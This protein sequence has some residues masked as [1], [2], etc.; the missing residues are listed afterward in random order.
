MTI[1]IHL[2]P[3]PARYFPLEKGIYEVAPGLSPLGA[4]FGNGAADEK[5]FQIDVEFERY[6]QN[7]ISCRLERLEK[8]FLTRDFDLG[9]ERAVS[10]FL[11]AR[12][13]VEYPDFFKYKD[14]TLDCLLTGD[15]LEFND[16]FDLVGERTESPN[17]PPFQSA[18]DALCSQ[19]Q[20]D[21]AVLRVAPDKRNWLAALHLCSPSHWA[22]EEKIGK[23]FFAIHAPVPGIEKVNQA[24]AQL[25]D[26]MVYKGPFVRFVWA[27]D[28][29][30]RLNQNP[31][32]PPG[33]SQDAW[34]RKLSTDGD[35]F[36]RIERQVIF[37]LPEVG[38]S[39]FTIRVSFIDG[40]EVRSDAQYRAA[41]RAAIVSMSPESRRY[42]GVPASFEEWLI[43]PE[44]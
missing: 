15:K 38:A 23:D 37:G 30:R 27:L 42:K 41:L 14:S 9:T 28:S 39:I 40:G 34:K 8:Y 10:R 11:A 5:M 26:A 19:I 24:S 29:S 32:P 17:D 1:P 13:Q 3:K 6:R 25:V 44:G 7:K 21:V 20:E 43:S 33:V 4:S 22:G 16:D 2:L 31:F 12:L 36:I 18:F 35:F